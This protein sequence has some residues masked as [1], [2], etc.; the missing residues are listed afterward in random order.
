MRQRL[1]WQIKILGEKNKELIR[2]NEELKKLDILKSDFLSLVSHELK[3]PL[4][5]IR[6]S[7]EFLDSEET[8]EPESGKK[9]LKMSSITLTG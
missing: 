4:S 1:N 8:M 7:A 9:C 5:A 3:T 2:A 6:T